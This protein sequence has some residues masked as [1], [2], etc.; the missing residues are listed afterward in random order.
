MLESIRDNKWYGKYRGFVRD[1]HDPERLGR[2]RLEVPAVLGAGA[3]CWSNWSSPCFPWGGND[4]QGCFMV[5]D[6]GA[7][8]WAEFEMGDPQYPIWTGFWIAG[9]NPGEQPSESKRLCSN[10]DCQDCEDARQHSSEPDSLEH[11]KYHDPSTFHCPRMRVLMKTE[12]GH[13]IL[14]DDKDGSETLKIIDR[15]GQCIVFKCPVEPGSQVGNTQRRGE[16]IATDGSQLSQGL[17]KG[18][19]ASVDIRDLARQG[20]LCSAKLGEEKVVLRAGDADLS[21]NESITM[22]STPGQ[23]RI[24]I[25]A[26]NAKKRILLR[27]KDGILLLDEYGNKICLSKEGVYIQDK[28]GCTVSMQGGN[29]QLFAPGVMAFNAAFYVFK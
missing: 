27:E 3:E 19:E 2:C 12:T 24:D 7:T 18:Q 17:M 1:N 26:A 20:M 16:K 22:D 5:P 21:R 13:T 4:D 8:V 23:E 29:M 14:A 10:A 11:G 6:E 9:S 25:Q 28:S 15:A